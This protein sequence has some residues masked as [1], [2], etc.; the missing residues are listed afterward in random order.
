MTIE[1]SDQEI[2]IQLGALEQEISR[3]QDLPERQQ[4]L[5]LSA[6]LEARS[7]QMET[8]WQQRKQERDKIRAANP[9]ER[10][11]NRESQLDSMERRRFKRACREELEPFD[12]TVREAD[13][14][15]LEIK[16]EIKSL[17]QKLQIHLRNNY[18]KSD[19]TP[20]IL[21]EDDYIIAIDKPSGFRSAPGRGLARQ[22][23]AFRDLQQVYPD[24]LI[25]HRLDQ[26]TSGV[27]LFAKGSDT[28]RSIH[29]EFLARRVK[30]RYEAI[31]AGRVEA[32]R[33]TIRLPLYGDKTNR[34]YQSVDYERGKIAITE[35]CVMER[36]L[37]DR[38]RIEFRP[39]TGRT[40]QLRVHAAVGLGYA[41]AGDRLYGQDEPDCG[42]DGEKRLCL[43]AASLGIWHRGEWL[44]ITAPVPF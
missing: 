31:L 42:E 9:Q 34:P 14:K 13:E 11:L 25:V 17:M 35:F 30:K 33:G 29:A 20:T 37:D 18:V 39:L 32:D 12:K 43:H 2:F 3:L 44:Q 10:D 27:L 28:A 36:G 4:L 40:H 16:R 24:I 8:K 23:S 7:Q 5:Q 19:K 1:L 6:E 21:Y 22:E 26:H 15:I 38:T 41:I